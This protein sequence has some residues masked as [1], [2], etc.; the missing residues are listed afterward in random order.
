[1]QRPIISLLLAIG[2]A[3]LGSALMAP[4]SAHKTLVGPDGHI[5]HSADG[6]PVIVPDRYRELRVN[7]ASYLCFIGATVSLIWTLFLV[8]FGVVTLIRQRPNQQVQP[9]ADGAVSSAPQSTPR[10]GGG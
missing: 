8:V 3:I 2:L 9:T 6:R 4:V 7:W 5:V 10:V 1:M